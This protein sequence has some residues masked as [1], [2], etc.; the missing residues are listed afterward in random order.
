MD[1]ITIVIITLFVI[2]FAVAGVITFIRNNNIRK[3]G[4]E[5]DADVV[6]IEEH[7]SVDSDGSITTTYTYYV[8]Y[9]AQDGK[10]VTAAVNKAPRKTRVGDVIKIKYLPEKPNYVVFV[11]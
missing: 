1:P 10:E 5:A 11:K 9:R 3:I 6:K 2:F 7:D 8:I 4:I